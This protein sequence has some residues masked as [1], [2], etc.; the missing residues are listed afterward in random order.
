MESFFKNIIIPALLCFSIVS[1]KAEIPVSLAKRVVKTGSIK[2]DGVLDEGIW[3]QADTVQVGTVWPSEAKPKHLTDVMTAWDSTYL[4]VAMIAWDDT[5]WATLTDRDA[6]LFSEEAV[7]VFFDPDGD[8]IN[9]TEF[10]FNCIGSILDFLFA[11]VG[12]N[13]ADWTATGLLFEPGVN[14]TANDNSDVDS[15]WVAEL[16]FAWADFADKSSITLPPSHGDILRINFN[17]AEKNKKNGTTEWVAWSFLPSGGNGFHQPDYFGKLEISDSL[18]YV[19]P[20]VAIHQGQQELISQALS[21]SGFRILYRIPEVSKVKLDVW[22]LDGSLVAVLQ[23]KIQS[24]G[25][26]SL[27]WKGENQQGEQV[28]SGL[29]LVRLHTGRSVRSQKIYLRDE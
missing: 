28:E 16:A 23:D 9:Y 10:N 25:T 19:E 27:N 12:D 1:L 22:S 18:A 8:G 20:I 17:R 6:S 26:Y 4:Y 7:E 15:F 5:I 3:Q 2:I 14:G 24:P 11:K 21:R 29:Y 13:I